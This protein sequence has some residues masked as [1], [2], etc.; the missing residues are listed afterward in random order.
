MGWDAL[1]L[2][3]DADCIDEPRINYPRVYWAGMPCGW[4]FEDYHWPLGLHGEGG[5]DE[6]G[7]E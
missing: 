2:G 5:M 1:C 6:N 3:R 4:G 7:Q